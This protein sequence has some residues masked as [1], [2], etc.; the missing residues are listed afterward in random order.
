MFE[1]LKF[2]NHNETST[3]EKEISLLNNI[4]NQLKYIYGMPNNIGAEF[5]LGWTLPNEFFNKPLKS[6][7]KNFK[8]SLTTSLK[9]KT[10]L[11]KENHIYIPALQPVDES[12]E[13]FSMIAFYVTYINSDDKLNYKP[14]GKYITPEIF[15]TIQIIDLLYNNFF[16]VKEI[17]FE[18]DKNL[19]NYGLFNKYFYNKKKFNSLKTSIHLPFNYEGEIWFKIIDLDKNIDD[20]HYSLQNILRSQFNSYN[21]HIDL[22]E[23]IETIKE[24]ISILKLID[25]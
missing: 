18:Y 12:E 20:L 22:K 21:G 23:N 1:S 5:S 24:K 19:K 15:K 10:K 13:Q 7:Q 16:V 4:K 25:Y 11:F 14:Y 3:E 6:L 2:F 17:E 8:T 9:Y